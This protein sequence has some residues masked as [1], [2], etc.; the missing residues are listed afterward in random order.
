MPLLHLIIFTAES[1]CKILWKSVSICQCYEEKY[2]DIFDKQLSTA[3]FLYHP[4]SL[5][6]YIRNTVG[7]A[8]VLSALSVA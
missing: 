4:L 6:N 1:N 8:V 3:G 2:S 7:K 5:A